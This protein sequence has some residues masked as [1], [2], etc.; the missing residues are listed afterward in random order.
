MLWPEAFL[1]TGYD[2]MTT[3]TITMKTTKPI[4]RRRDYDDDDDDDDDGSDSDDDDDDDDS[5]VVYEAYDQ[6]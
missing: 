2:V 5:D 1:H 6:R 3:K 4:Q